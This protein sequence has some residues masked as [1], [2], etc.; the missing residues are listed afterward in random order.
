MGDTADNIPGVPSIGEKTATKIITEYH[1]IENAHEHVEELK[2][3]RASKALNEHWDL[4][5]LSKTLATIEVHADVEYDFEEAK[6]GNLYTEEAYTY[7]QRLQFKNLLSRFDV[8]PEAPS[9][10][11]TFC[12]IETKKEAETYLKKL[13]EAKVV[14]A[15]VYKDTENVLPLFAMQAALG[16]VAFCASQ[17]KTALI[18]TGGEISA[19]WLLEQVSQI[20]QKAGQFV[21]FDLKNVIAELPIENRAIVL[22]RQLRRIF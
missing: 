3:P 1:S 9:I 8:Q 5:V 21:V 15:A 6:L 2:P 14:G 7:F 17:E 19:E 10:E 4:A 18:L 22:M 11:E 20:Q 12:A 13:E 16:G